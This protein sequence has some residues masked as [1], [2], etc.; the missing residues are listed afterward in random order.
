MY[1]HF[2]HGIRHFGRGQSDMFEKLLTR[3]HPLKHIPSVEK[4]VTIGGRAVLVSP[5]VQGEVYKGGQL[6]GILE[7]LRECRTNG[8]CLTNICPENL[9]VNGSD[10]KYIDLGASIEEFSDYL[11]QE[12]CKRAYLTYRWYFR[13]D[14][15]ELLTKSLRD[16]G[17]SRIVWL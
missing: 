1:K 17:S 15:K 13:K 2:H 5:L 4:V 10:V 16:D 12:M 6:N 8:I 9:L 7:L 3:E 14:L 11:F